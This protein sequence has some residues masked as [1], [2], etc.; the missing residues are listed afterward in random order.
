MI[1]PTKHVSIN[2]CLLGSGSVVLE[3]LKKPQ[4]VTRLWERLKE[5]PDIVTYDR[6][7]LALDLLYVIGVLDFR[8]GLLRRQRRDS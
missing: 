5:H 6:F 2:R 3:N 1:L 7:I 8:E 4:T